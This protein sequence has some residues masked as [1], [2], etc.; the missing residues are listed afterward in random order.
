MPSALEKTTSLF[1]A[2]LREALP[3]VDVTV[4]R[5]TNRHGGKSNYVYLGR[6]R[7]MPLKVRISDHAI[8]MKRAL[9]R[10]EALY[11]R[12][13]AKPDSWAVWLGSLCRQLAS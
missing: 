4:Q 9:E 10:N 8:G 12:A 5:S 2:S 1:V 6:P 11:I 7:A 13:G 3:A